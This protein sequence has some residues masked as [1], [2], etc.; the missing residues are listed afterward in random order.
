MPGS[1]SQRRISIPLLAGVLF[2][3]PLL[4]Q[5]VTE[6]CLDGEFDLGARYQGT[7]PQSGESYATSWCV[8]TE[9]DSKRVM[10]S[11]TGKSNPDM[12]GS[13]TVAYLPPDRVRIVNRDSP[14]DVEFNDTDNLDEALRVRRIDPRRLADE[15][16]QT[17]EALADVQIETH[18][19]RLQSAKTS[20]ELPLRGRVDV[21]WHWDWSTPARPALELMLDD[22]LLFRATGRWR[23]LPAE[24]AAKVWLATPG[25]E[26]VQVA[27]DRWPA[28]IDM[29]VINLA[30]GVSVV[31][32][33]RTGFQHLVVETDKGLVVADAP[34]G[35]VEFHQLPPSDLVPGF[36]VSGLSENF[37]D[38]LAAEFPGKPIDAVVLTHFHDDHAGG[39]RAFAAA[40]A[41]I[42]TTEESVEFFTKALNRPSMP[43]DRL[44]RLGTYVE[45]LPVADPLVI[46]SE[47]NRVRLMPLGAG[48][49]AYAMLGVWALDKD[50]FFVSDVHVPRSDADA[51]SE[52][53]AVT[54]CWFAEWAVNK[55]PPSVQVAN[56]HSTNMTPVSRLAKYLESDACAAN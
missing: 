38:F 4:G 33:V 7:R 41:D 30:D 5:G 22:E 39:A 37:I 23:D 6:F 51:P 53:R 32:G 50:Y 43:D 28:S 17:P 25:E 27:G 9:D 49:H 34:A 56:S 36:G 46:G 13:W 35:W 24:E 42:Y 55:L 3:G 44:A 8:T 47:P 20:T 2:S 14:P 12:E 52:N 48:P 26:P 31:R 16:R 29:Q 40:G 21:V 1:I 45:V 11:G 10:F 15:Y 19:D 18:G 54:E